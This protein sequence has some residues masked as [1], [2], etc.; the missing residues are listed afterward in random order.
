MLPHPRK[1]GSPVDDSNKSDGDG[2]F[3]RRAI[4]L[5]REGDRK[6]GANPIG[7]VIVLDGEIIG[8][9]YGEGY[10]EADIRH[11][12]DRRSCSNFLAR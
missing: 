3:M 4:A 2:R 10:N 9:G 6:P 7:R 1:R 12:A 5:A 8:E 11:A